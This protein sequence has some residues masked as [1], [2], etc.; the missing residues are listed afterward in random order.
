MRSHK[1]KKRAFTLIELLVVIA[2]IATL[3]SVIVPSLK[4]AKD[5]AK[6]MICRSNVRNLT[7]AAQLWSED[8]NGWVLPALWDRGSQGAD[9][10]MDN[11]F[12]KGYLD[13]GTGDNVMFCPA[14]KERHAGKTYGELGFNAAELAAWG[15]TPTNY[16]NSYGYNIKLC[17]M[18][19][20]CP[21]DYDTA[22]HDGSQWGRENVWY[23]EH[24]NCK[25]LTIDVP[26]QKIM[27]VESFVYY[28]YP[29]LYR[30]SSN[31]DSILRY[32]AD[33]GLRHNV[34]T[35]RAGSSEEQAGITN[36]GWCDG[37][38]SPAPKDFEEFD[39]ARGTYERTGKYWYGKRNW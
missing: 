39:E 14:M 20:G 37:S 18:T 17:S 12:L 16:I 24:G 36:I 31:P 10:S 21:G 8:N 7:L 34:K 13:T 3:L 22:N 33:R 38:V 15:V 28:A 29:E 6:N 30:T 23:S 19:G 25:L 2:I 35:R 1:N 9:G 27:F 4:K 11:S 32:P 5:A 26:Y